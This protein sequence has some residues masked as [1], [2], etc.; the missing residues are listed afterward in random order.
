MKVIDLTPASTMTVGEA[1]KLV[2]VGGE[3]RLAAG[4]Y[5]FNAGQVCSTLLQRSQVTTMRYAGPEWP[6]KE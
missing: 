4:N 1:L 3:V 5:R 2:G 6:Q